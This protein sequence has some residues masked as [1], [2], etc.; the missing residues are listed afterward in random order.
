MITNKKRE[1]WIDISKTLLIF[2]MVVGHCQPDSWL[3]TLIYGCHMP[4]FFMISGYL[5][6]PHNWKKTTRSFFVPSLIFGTINLGLLYSQLALHNA[7][8]EDALKR[9]IQP[10]FMITYGYGYNLYTGFWFIVCLY[11]CRLLCGDIQFM[12]HKK[13]SIYLI[14][15]ACSLFMTMREYWPNAIQQYK[16][17]SLYLFRTIACIPFFVFGIWCKQHQLLQYITYPIALFSLVLYIISC[18]LN[19]PVDMWATQYGINYLITAI[20]SII[21]FIALSKLTAIPI[22]SKFQPL[23]KV[24]SIGTLFILGL[25]APIRDCLWYVSNGIIHNA[26]ITSAT[27]MVI[28]YYPIKYSINNYPIILGK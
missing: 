5:Y 14:A 13:K 28:C 21:S 6:S 27:I 1:D 8:P 7:I 16:I 26:I 4:A 2:S 22:S 17:D 12:Q 3:R 10:L 25:H 19:G 15:I 11:F 18:N 23:F 24:F 20:I 9:T